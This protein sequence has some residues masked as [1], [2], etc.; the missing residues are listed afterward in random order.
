MYTTI[1]F[2]IIAT[3]FCLKKQY[4]LA[5]LIIK[6]LLCHKFKK[7]ISSIIYALHNFVLNYLR[8]VT[9]LLIAKHVQLYIR[10]FITNYF[11]W[12]VSSHSRV[13]KKIYLKL[14]F[15]SN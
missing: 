9:F 4:L 14:Y 10:R 15:S 1:V 3:L 11:E 2:Q 13:I 7:I 8:F 5:F 12:N 6:K